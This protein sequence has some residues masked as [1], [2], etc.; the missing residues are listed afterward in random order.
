MDE[1]ILISFLI[2][3][4]S[5]IIIKNIIGSAKGQ[6]SR[7]RKSDIGCAIILAIA[8][9]MMALTMSHFIEVNKDAAAAVDERLGE[10][11]RRIE[12]GIE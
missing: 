6:T 5:A 7:R 1:N 10:A 2:I 12:V 3:A 4:V 9:V 8:V 11:E